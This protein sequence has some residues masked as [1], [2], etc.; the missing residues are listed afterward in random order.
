MRRQITKPELHD[1]LLPTTAVMTKRV[2]VT[3]QW[4]PTMCRD[5]VEV[6]TD[7]ITRLTKTGVLTQSGREVPVDVVVQAT[8]FDASKFVLPMQVIGENGKMLADVWGAAPHA[9]YGLAVPGFPNFF[10][11]YGPGTNLGHNSILTMVDTQVD[12]I[13]RILEKLVCSAE[14]AAG[15]THTV[16]VT[17]EAHAAYRAKA[18]A[19]LADTVWARAGQR[20]WYTTPEGD[21]VNN[22]YGSCG[23][24]KREMQTVHEDAW[25]YSV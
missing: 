9:F 1:V 11:L 14:A 7:P 10:H 4:L 21:V 18:H 3:N 20:T 16:C 22:W 15:A 23:E 13:G 24:Y 5:D 25:E 17:D 19:R 12:Y 2:M 8:G 6:V